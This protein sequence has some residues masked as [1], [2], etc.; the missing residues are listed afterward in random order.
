MTCVAVMGEKNAHDLRG[1]PV[2]RVGDELEEGADPEPPR[3][4]HAVLRRE[5]SPERDA[6]V[7]ACPELQCFVGDAISQVWLDPHGVQ[8]SFES[9]RRLVVEQRIEQ[10]EPNGTIWGYDCEAAS[11]PP[12]ILHRLL[13]KRIVAV[14]REDLRLTFRIDDGSSL[15]IFSELGPYESGNIQAQEIGFV[16]F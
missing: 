11:G 10:V 4:Q 7:S 13:Y 6:A 3:R 9:M 16:V 1:G 12:L 15:T 14:E 5:G 2:D 8:F